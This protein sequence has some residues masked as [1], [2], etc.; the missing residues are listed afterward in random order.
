MAVGTRE[1]M[2]ASAALLIRERGARATSIDD[3]LQHAGAPR[4]SVYHH[5]PGG[6][7]EL[8]RE[9]TRFAG[10][11]TGRRLADWDEFVERYRRALLE[12]DF[13]PGCPVLAIAI[14]DG[15]LQ[16]EAGA[17][18]RDWTDALAA[19]FTADG[20]PTERAPALATLAISAA[21]GALALARSQRDVT[22]LD[23]VRDELRALIDRERS[24]A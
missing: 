24:P 13:K 9:A 12:H 8:L 4:G 3:V 17:V 2:I 20:V 5:F 14:E 11:V 15:D 7:E 6:R 16:A 18:F 19:A 23:R 22:P 21:E 1:R 10:T